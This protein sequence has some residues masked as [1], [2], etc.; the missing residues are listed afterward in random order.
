MTLVSKSMKHP[1]LSA[2]VLRVSRHELLEPMECTHLVDSHNGPIHDSCSR[3][4]SWDWSDKQSVR[5]KH[6]IQSARNA[7]CSLGFA[8]GLL[9][10]FTH[11]DESPGGGRPSPTS[12]SVYHE[13]KRGF[14]ERLMDLSSPK[15]RVP[16]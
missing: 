7:S 1:F 3:C 4:S 10:Y 8:Y 15:L 13:V 11:V 5:G 16:L 9:C 2:H 12:A 6:A 14:V